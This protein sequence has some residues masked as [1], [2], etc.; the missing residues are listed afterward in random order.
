MKKQPEEFE[1]TVIVHS[2]RAA[3][4]IREMKRRR[5]IRKYF[6]EHRWKVF[7]RTWEGAEATVVIAVLFAF[8]ALCIVTGFALTPTDTLFDKLV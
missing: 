1:F 4:A 2:E 7:T 8:A 3:E 5:K 6:L